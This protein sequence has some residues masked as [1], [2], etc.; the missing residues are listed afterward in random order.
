MKLANSNAQAAV[1]I[2]VEMSEYYNKFMFE[3]PNY[4]PLLKSIKSR[5]L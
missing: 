5:K 1:N 2:L 4:L 3:F